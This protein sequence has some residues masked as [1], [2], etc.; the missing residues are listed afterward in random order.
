[1]TTSLDDLWYLSNIIDKDDTLSGRT[2]R[3]IKLGE[4]E[5]NTRI[6]KKV[7]TLAIKVE[8]VEFHKYSNSLRVSGKIISAPEDIPKGSYHTFDV[9]DNTTLKISKPNWLNYQIEKLKEFF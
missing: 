3:K 8:R 5:R 9:T 4:D 7:I 6:I 1:M 2:I